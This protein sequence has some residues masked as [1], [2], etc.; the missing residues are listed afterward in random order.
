MRLLVF[1]AT[2]NEIGNIERLCSEIIKCSDKVEVLVVDDS[3]PDGTGEL[4]DRMNEVNNR[5]NVVHRPQKSGVGS[6]H[7][8]A[9]RYAHD[10]EI[11][12]LITMD[13]D[14]SHP[15]EYIKKFLE[16]MHK[17]DYLVASRYA[18]GGS[19]EYK[20]TRLFISKS[21]NIL[22]KHVL[23]LKM[24]E[25][26]SSFRG[27]SRK[28][29][30]ALLD[31]DITADGYS[32]FLETSYWVERLGLSVYEFGFSFKDRSEGVSKISKREIFKAVLKLIRLRVS[33]QVNR[34]KV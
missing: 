9:L 24:T 4:L 29:V 18:Y 16:S 19:T 26:T 2:Y 10:N 13:A 22:A 8:M 11:D 30:D 1:T 5:I 34:S 21:A 14:F 33:G 25:C 27:F 31:V 32:Y 17:A 7:K 20:G 6:A 3:S 28:A 15:P 23:R 12:F